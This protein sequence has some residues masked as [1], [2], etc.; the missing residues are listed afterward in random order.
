MR[1]SAISPESG[2]HARRDVRGFTLIEILLVLA[3]LGLLLT[4]TAP[5]LGK[6][7]ARIGVNSDLQN[8]IGGIGALPLLAFALGEEGTLEELAER[9]L[10][11]PDGWSMQGGKDIYVRANGVCSGGTLRLVWPEGTRVLELE[12]PFCSPQQENK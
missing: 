9:H 3:L 6:L 10:E 2:R 8:L 4:L 7:Y 1:I 5:A 12:A 11:L